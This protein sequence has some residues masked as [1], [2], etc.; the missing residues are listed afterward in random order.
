MELKNMVDELINSGMMES[1]ELGVVLMTSPDMPQEEVIK[2][3]DKFIKDYNK[4]PLKYLDYDNRT[5]FEKWVELYQ[6]YVKSH[7]KNRVKKIV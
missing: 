3:I 2:H 4:Q 7:V 5:L 1:E 6:L